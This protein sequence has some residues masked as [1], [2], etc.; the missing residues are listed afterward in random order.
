MPVKLNIKQ[1]RCF[2]D[3]KN[4]KSYVYRQQKDYKLPHM[5]RFIL[6]LD[7][8]LLIIL[9]RSQNEYS[10]T[11]SPTSLLSVKLAKLKNGVKP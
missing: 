5:N 4:L 11:C 2:I 1:I 6:N 10:L 7:R 3:L 8:K 9:N